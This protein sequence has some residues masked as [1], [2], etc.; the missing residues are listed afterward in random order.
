M[1]A[2]DLVAILQTV[3][4]TLTFACVNNQFRCH[5]LMLLSVTR[6]NDATQAIHQLQRKT[7][8]R[9]VFLEVRSILCSPQLL[10]WP[11]W[12]GDKGRGLIGFPF[13]LLCLNLYSKTWF[14]LN[15]QAS[16]LL[17]QSYSFFT[18]L[19]FSPPTRTV[20]SFFFSFSLYHRWMGSLFT[21]QHRTHSHVELERHCWLKADSLCAV[22]SAGSL[23]A[24]CWD[25]WKRSDTASITLRH[26]FFLFFF[27]RNFVPS[28]KSKS[29]F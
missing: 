23:A 25:S 13:L 14:L 24:V 18:K 8:W 9:N 10:H 22:T 16:L 19:E 7:W 27:L 21:V 5:S 12:L 17:I 26:N 15:P 3:M 4:A 1:Y 20:F 11:I 6:Y 29:D 28:I 2:E